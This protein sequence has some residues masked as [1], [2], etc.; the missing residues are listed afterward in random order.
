MA[1][2]ELSKENILPMKS[3]RDVQ[4]LNDALGDHV[5]EWKEKKMQEWRLYQ[6]RLVENENDSEALLEAYYEYVCSCYLSDV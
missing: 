2:W 4:V 5:S 6:D 3:G 1:N